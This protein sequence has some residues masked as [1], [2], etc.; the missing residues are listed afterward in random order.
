MGGGHGLAVSV[1]HASSE[2]NAFHS[3]RREFDVHVCQ[4][5]P[6]PSARAARTAGQDEGPTHENGKRPTSASLLRPARRFV[7]AIG[8]GYFWAENTVHVLSDCAAPPWRQ[9]VPSPANSA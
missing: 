3:A 8:A 7:D 1:V 9:W 4:T 5:E 6:Q 2:R